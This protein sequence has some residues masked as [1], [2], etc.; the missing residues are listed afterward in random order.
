MTSSVSDILIISLSE[1]G[2]MVRASGRPTP[3]RE[4][5]RCP[6]ALPRPAAPRPLATHQIFSRLGAPTAEWGSSSKAS[7]DRTKWAGPAAVRRWSGAAGTGPRPPTAAAGM[8]ISGG[9]GAGAYSPLPSGPQNPRHPSPESGGCG[10]HA[11]EDGDRRASAEA[12]SRGRGAVGATI[13]P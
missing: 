2:R 6:P 4:I 3:G 11:S 10:S 8:F 1:D 13:A 5:V 12:I 7:G 9:L